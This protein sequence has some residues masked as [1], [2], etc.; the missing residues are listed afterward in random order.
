MIEG[1]KN[2]LRQAFLDSGK[3]AVQVCR[4]TGVTRS[5][6]YHH[7]NGAGMNAL[8]LAR[9]AVAFKVSADWLLGLKKERTP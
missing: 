5:C 2:R 6:F 9:Y 1:M 3:T 4:E 7:L 8:T